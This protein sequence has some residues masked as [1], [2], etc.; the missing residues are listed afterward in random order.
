MLKN[1]FSWQNPFKQI[2]NELR[3]L[4]ARPHQR[5]VIRKSRNVRSEEREELFFLRYK[6]LI[7]NNQCFNKHMIKSP[8]MHNGTSGKISLAEIFCF[9]CV[10]Y[11]STF[12]AHARRNIQPVGNIIVFFLSC[13][14]INTHPLITD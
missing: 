8:V 11:T 5:T 12:C 6:F 1:I 4:C 3:L 2:N 14:S 9:C 13:K 10:E 7:L